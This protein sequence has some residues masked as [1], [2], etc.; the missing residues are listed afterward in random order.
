MTLILREGRGGRE[1]LRKEKNNKL[2]IDSKTKVTCRDK[3]D[4][5]IKVYPSGIVGGLNFLMFHLNAFPF[6]VKPLYCL[7]STRLYTC[8]SQF[9]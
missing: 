1:T 5:K 4:D 2:I 9:I 7:N 3:P 8:F 6:H